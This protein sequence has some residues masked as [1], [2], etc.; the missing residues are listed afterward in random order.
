MEV[1]NKFQIGQEVFFLDGN[2]KAVSDTVNYVIAYIRKDGVSFSYD[3]TKATV[4]LSEDKVFESKAALMNHI[5]GSNVI[6]FD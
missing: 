3:L 4:F 2:G 5:F 6:D 1:N